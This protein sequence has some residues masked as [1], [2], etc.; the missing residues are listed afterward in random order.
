MI[1]CRVDQIGR[2]RPSLL[3]LYAGKAGRAK[4]NLS[5]GQP[6][7]DPS[8]EA[9]E[10]VNKAVARTGHA[11]YTAAAGSARLLAEVVKYFESLGFANSGEISQDNVVVSHGAKLLIDVA[12][13]VLCRPGDRVIW[14]GP[15]Y[16]Y[17]RS[18]WFNNLESVM[19]PC[20]PPDFNPDLE[21]LE[22]ELVAAL[23]DRR[24]ATVI[25]NSPANPT[26]RVWSQADMNGLV[27]LVTSF[28][29]TSVI[30]DETYAGLVYSQENNIFG[31]PTWRSGMTDKTV[32]IRSGSKGMRLPGYRLG[33]ACGP[34]E[35][36]A[37]MNSLLG[38]C[39]GCP[40]VLTQEVAIHTLSHYRQCCLE[41]L[42]SLL[43][44][45]A[46][47]Q[48]WL[49]NQQLPFALIEGA[50][51]AFVDFSRLLNLWHQ[52]DTIAMVDKLLL[53]YGVGIIPGPAFGESYSDFSTWARLS[54]AGPQE[55]LALGLSRLG[56][57]LMSPK[58]VPIG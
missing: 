20:Q 46:I 31:S 1:N 27:D 3:Q 56:Q 42:P 8:P 54:F 35:I 4:I 44:K 6:E 36:I 37:A 39:V 49:D 19:I 52:C 34:Q 40:N 33:L 26:G 58:S 28:P 17:G 24:L 21:Q 57:A 5:V 25:I 11:G 48:S 13:R 53:E 16:T 23:E 50:F 51:Y 55:K 43:E 41:Q 9:V 30:A 14:F 29:G 18:A 38:D 15:G 32:V 45:R 2:L 10:A 12:L 47:L 7:M 22:T